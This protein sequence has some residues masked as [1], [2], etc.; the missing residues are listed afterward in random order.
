MECLNESRD[1]EL[2][3]ILSYTR[4]SPWCWVRSELASPDASRCW[5]GEEEETL[6]VV[7]ESGYVPPQERMPASRRQPCG[8]EVVILRG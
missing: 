5:L 6:W 2:G 1:L 7:G 8:C 3:R 4:L